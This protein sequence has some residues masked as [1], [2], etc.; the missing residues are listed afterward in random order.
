MLNSSRDKIRRIRLEGAY[1]SG[2]GGEEPTTTLR[3]PGCELRLRR[4]QREQK[5]D[6]N[7]CHGMKN[8][9]KWGGMVCMYTEP[10]SFLIYG[11][12]STVS[13]SAGTTAVRVH[14]T[15][16]CVLVSFIEGLCV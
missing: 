9:Q 14:G 8:I 15:S 5:G 2:E 3:D 13:L 12:T 1:R 7:Q 11:S 10:S 16:S 4:R 6:D